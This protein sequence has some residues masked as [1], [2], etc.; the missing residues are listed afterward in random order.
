MTRMY[1]IKSVFIVHSTNCNILEAL[2]NK[3]KNIKNYVKVI[4]IKMLFFLSLV[5]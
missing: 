3:Y 4:T 5:L 2:G 1:K